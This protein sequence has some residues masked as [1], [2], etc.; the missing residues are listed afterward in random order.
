M[1]Y[2]SVSDLRQD[3]REVAHELP[4]DT[5]LVVAVPRSGVLA[6]NLLCL[7]LDVPMT[8]VD[9]LCRRDMFE[10]GNRHERSLS[11]DDIGTAI[12]FDDSVYPGT[13]MA[14]T[15]ER[16]AG[17]DF[18]F[19]L[20]YGAAYVTEDGLDQVDHWGKVV[21]SPRVFEWNTLHHSN[22]ENFCVDIDGVLCRDPTE[23]ENDDGE[24]YLEFLSGVDPKIRPNQRIGWLVTC[25]LEKY[26]EETEVWLDEHGIEYD[27]LVMMDHPDM[28]A[29]REAGDHGAFKAEV[30]EETDA[31]LFIESTPHQAVEICERTDK[32]VYCFET[33]ELIQPGRIDETYQE[34]T[35]YLSLFRENPV[36]F[37]IA[38]GEFLLRQV[39]ARIRR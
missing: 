32:P 12:V 33:N 20:E 9:G 26:R 30:Y 34:E 24:N 38:A 22:L 28:E 17:E 11:I 13:Q 18:P 16:V 36:G 14:E 1:N 5:D 2:R 35:E 7:Y 6:A 27:E 8:D 23:A 31:E 37:S 21:P 19:D 29:R 15:R 25:R 4:P 3:M 10:T 39:R